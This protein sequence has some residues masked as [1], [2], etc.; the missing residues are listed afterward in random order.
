MEEDSL[1]TTQSPLCQESQKDQ[2]SWTKIKG[3]V[4]RSWET[5]I[6][7]KTSKENSSTICQNQARS[8]VQ[9]QAKPNKIGTAIRIL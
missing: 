4:S 7:N 2:E 5:M 1:Q 9:V 8:L 3:L 6:Q